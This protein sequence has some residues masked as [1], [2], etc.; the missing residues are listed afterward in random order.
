MKQAHQK[1]L[2]PKKSNYYYLIGGSVFCLGL[3]FNLQVEL[4][5]A[6]ELCEQDTP[7]IE[8]KIEDATFSINNDDSFVIKDHNLYVGYEGNG[9]L[10]IING[11]MVHI[12]NDKLIVG[13]KKNSN[14]SITI[15]KNGFLQLDSGNAVIAESDHSNGIINIGSA[16]GDAAVAPGYLLING[17]D[18]GIVFGQGNGS[19]VFNHTDN[20]YVF[21][22]MITGYGTI[23]VKNGKTIINSNSGGFSGDTI[24]SDGTLSVSSGATLGGN[25]EVKNG[26]V[27]S[28]A[29]T[30]GTANTGDVTIDTGGTIAP[31]NSI[32]TLKVAGDLFFNPGSIYA[33]EVDP[34][35]A[36]SDKIHVGGSAKLAGSVVH[37]GL[38]GNYKP[39]STYNILTADNGL[40]GRFDDVS[41][42]FAF[43]DPVLKYDSHNVNLAL[44][45]NNVQFVD[46]AKTSNQKSTAKGIASLPA[47]SPLLQKFELL[48]NDTPASVLDGLS[49]EAHAG[50]ATALRQNSSQAST[51]ALSYLR[52]N[53]SAGYLPGAMI[54][55]AS[56]SDYMPIPAQAMPRS[57][58]LPLWF[59]AIGSKQRINGDSNTADIKQDTYGMF[60]G[61]DFSVGNGWRLGASLGYANSKM[62]MDNRNSKADIDTYTVTTYGGK[63][64]PMTTSNA[65]LNLLMG[66]SY[67][68]HKIKTDRHVNLNDWSHKLK[69]NYKANT[70]QLFGELSYAMQFYDFTIEPF[71][72]L[73][74]NRL[75]IN[76]FTESGGATALSSKSHTQNNTNSILGVRAS[77]KFDIGQSTA[78]ASAGLGWQH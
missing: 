57:A 55:Q 19:L 8:C 52:S 1:T 53:M 3:F 43:L 69:S 33:V 68:W 28:G 2:T 25:I 22:P 44:E 21:D 17:V 73:E 32:G 11:G 77:S 7:L 36:T 66:A 16:S 31:G 65:K 60:T 35:G 78:F 20:N 10:D 61:G 4:A 56:Y 38:N 18:K 42:N 26:A 49:G 9:V 70:T 51:L 27:L 64:F 72:G 67:S 41:S 39:R 5:F 40:V 29:G 74:F 63:S 62:R 14:S 48:S 50:L 46:F 12:A 34:S 30:F 6:A 45:R 37:I 23:S 75:S 54:A 24:V 13:V 76:S 47:S 59:Q 15:S 58:A 71:V